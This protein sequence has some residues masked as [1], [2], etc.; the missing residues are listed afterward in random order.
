MSAEWTMQT[1]P[2]LLL[3]EGEDQGG[4]AELRTESQRVLAHAGGVV[5]ITTEADKQAAVAAGRLVQAVSKQ[6][7]E[8]YKGYKSRIDA[9]KRVVLEDERVDAERASQEKNRLGALVLAWDTEQERRRKEEERLARE[10]AQR[11][12]EEQR[13]LEAIALEAEGHVEEAAA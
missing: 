5:A 1:A 9:V 7:T 4:V 8:F 2:Q 6:V 13:L 10:A 12:A 3:P 11:E